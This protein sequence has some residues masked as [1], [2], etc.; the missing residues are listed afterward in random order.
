MHG[1]GAPLGRFSAQ[2]PDE[3]HRAAADVARVLR[4]ARRVLV[5][6]HAGADGDVAG[7]SLAIAAALRERGAD[8]VVYNPFPYPSAFSWLPGGDGIVHTIDDDAV[9][10]ATVV[11]DAADPARCGDGLLEPARRGTFVWI[12]HHRIDAPPG[13][14][15]FIDLTSAAVGEQVVLVLDALAHPLSVD[16][17][18]CV[19]ASLLSDTGAF[20]YANTSARA[21]RLAARLVEA[22]VDP[23]QMTEHIYESQDEA[24][25]RLTGHVLSSFWRSSSD[26]FAVGLVTSSDLMRSQASHEHVQGIVNH[27]RAVRGVEIAALVCETDDGTRVYLRGKGNVP[28]AP[29]AEALGFMAANKN[30]A[31]FTL[32]E[33]ATM[34]HERLLTI[35]ASVDARDGF[36]APKP[37]RAARRR[38]RR[39]LAS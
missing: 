25:T 32:A 24:R 29:V 8:V 16:V 9:F 17:A 23:W 10:D 30:A 28:C 38:P 6:G 35:F 18:K 31:T 22:G 11:V 19:Y 3:A 36:V 14:V 33:D 34:V 20:R 37:L 1:T 12:D 39:A 5:M 13:D 7:S 21:L 15:N 27:L 2:V 26:R 4:D